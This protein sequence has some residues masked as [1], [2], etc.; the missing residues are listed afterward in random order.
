MEDDSYNIGIGP[1]LFQCESHTLSIVF[2]KPFLLHHL[3]RQSLNEFVKSFC[4]VRVKVAR[5]AKSMI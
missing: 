5:L 2:T 3:W 4:A 1:T